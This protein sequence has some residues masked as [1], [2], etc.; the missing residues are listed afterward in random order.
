MRTV[1]GSSWDRTH[2]RIQEVA[3]TLFERHGFEDT[4]VAQI[5]ED[6]GVSEMTVFRHF[7][8]KHGVLFDDPYDDIIVGAVR[9]QPR[10][11]APLVR[12]VAGV[13]D[14]WRMVPEPETDLVR[15]R[16][17]IVATTTELRGE[18][19]RNNAVTEALISDQLATDGADP[20]HAKIASAAV[21]AGVTAALFEWSL[22]DQA[23]LG[24]CIEVAL[25]VLDGRDG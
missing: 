22:Q 11:L 8:S 23:P 21:L 3:L 15:R 25:N 17:R 1:H 5:A 13:R 24:D 18:M 6:A 10:G 14:S 4:T 19:S 7:A 2:V 20:V 12:A 9:E 16:V